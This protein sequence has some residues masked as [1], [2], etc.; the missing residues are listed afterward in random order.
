M[1]EYQIKYERGSTSFE[2]N[3]LSRNSISYYIRPLSFLLNPSKIIAAKRVKYNVYCKMYK[4]ENII[5]IV[6]QKGFQ[7]VVVPKA[8][9]SF[10]SCCS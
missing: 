7:K 6:K 10:F 4:T 8:L 5:I 9:R 3:R 2:A 1:F